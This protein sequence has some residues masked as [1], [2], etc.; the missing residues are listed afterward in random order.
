MHVVIDN[1]VHKATMPASAKSLVVDRDPQRRALVT[2]L[3]SNMGF[4]TIGSGGQ[5]PEVVKNLSTKTENLFLVLYAE[6]LS[7]NILQQ[8]KDL[9]K[10][11]PIPVLLLI[12]DLEKEGMA[13]AMKAGVTAFISLGV[14]GN[15]IKHAINSAFANFDLVS[16]LQKQISSLENRLENRIIIDK[17]KGLIMK[18]RGLDEAQA[19]DY[20]RKYAMKSG[21]K[22]IDVAEMTIATA[23][24]L[25]KEG[26]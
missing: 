26:A 18:N 21:K 5:I 8:L 13:T 1:Q 10:Q 23:E 7:N 19:Y 20:L 4:N 3:L 16:D 14:Q 22:M 25:N 12:D 11:R 6:T 9:Q 17:A 24:L 15:R 2:E